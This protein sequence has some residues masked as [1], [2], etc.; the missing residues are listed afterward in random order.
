MNR[1]SPIAFA[2]ALVATGL[3]VMASSPAQA[4]TR[5]VRYGDLDLSTA[6]GRATLGN[7]IG[8]AATAVCQSENFTLGAIQ[9]CRR[10]S[11]ANASATLDR[12]VQN[13]SVQLASR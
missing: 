4:A 11:I 10:E 3:T 5:H 13:R 1:L 2:A 9:A 8:H 12:I 7:R 6:A